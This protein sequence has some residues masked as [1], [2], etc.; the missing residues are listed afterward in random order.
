MTQ[1][2]LKVLI[3]HFKEL[4]E[5]DIAGITSTDARNT[6][7]SWLEEIGQENNAWK[8]DLAVYTYQT[9]PKIAKMEKEY[10]S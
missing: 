3:K 4:V 7:T 8:F 6:I 1:R 9:S 10:N 2:E 5:Q